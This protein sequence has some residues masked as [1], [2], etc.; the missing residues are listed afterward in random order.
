MKQIELE[1]K[2]K[3]I[4]KYLTEYSQEN[5]FPPSIREICDTFNIKSTAS[6]HTYLNKMKDKGWLD[7]LPAKKRALVLPAQKQYKSVPLVGSIKAGYPNFAYENLE[8]YYPLPSD[9]N[10]VDNIFALKVDGDSM[11]NAGIY[12]KDVILVR[13]QEN[14]ENGEIVVAL[15]DD[16]ATVKRFY[17]KNNKIILH[18]EN[19]SLS[20]MIF[21]DVKILGVVKG[22]YRKI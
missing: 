19:D 11:I 8:G 13:Q 1:E 15:I 9:F 12:D 21:D 4:Y 16:M 5:G 3:S 7:K 22:L 17:R 18:P 14:A 10:V 6:V 2:I 20:D